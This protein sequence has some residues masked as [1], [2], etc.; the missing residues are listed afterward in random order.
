MLISKK[1]FVSF[2]LLAC[3]LVAVLLPVSCSYFSRKPNFIFITVDTLRADH[4]P[5]GN[6]SRPTMPA[7]QNF[8]RNAVNFTHAETPRSLTSPAFASLMTGLYPYRHGVRKVAGKLNDQHTTLAEMLRQHGYYTAAVVSSFVM[9]GRLSGFDQGFDY[10]DDSLVE[11]HGTFTSNAGRSVD[12]VLSALKKL[13]TDRP[14]FL[15]LHFIDPHGPYDPPNSF[16]IPFHSNQQFLL[17]IDQIPAYQRIPG[18]LNQFDY[19]DRYDAEIDYL[20]S[21][22][23]RLYAAL[24]PYEKN[25]WFLFTAD[26]GESMGEHGTYFEHGSS[27]YETQTHVPMLWLAPSQNVPAAKRGNTV[28]LVDIYPTILEIAKLPLPKE[29]DGESLLSM[30]KGNEP[31]QHLRYIERMKTTRTE[32]VAVSDRYKMIVTNM[33]ERELYDLNSDPSETHNLL[34]AV[35]PP[36]ELAKATDSFMRAAESYKLPFREE[37]FERV[38]KSRAAKQEWMKKHQ[39]RELSEEDKEKLKSLGYVDD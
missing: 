8:F 14:F 2:A 17:S 29:N 7:T 39:Q 27:C 33:G 5:F 13:P 36:V 4:T 11:M 26:H 23:K 16:P 12:R 21:E 22:L 1:A 18:V 19:I 9:V 28:S 35:T 24:Q 15:F 20:D 38:R 3:I 6:Y 30:I 32:Y 34:P 37:S 31:K 10:Y 25:S